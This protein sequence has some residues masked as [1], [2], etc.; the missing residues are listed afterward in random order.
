M[1]VW[2]TFCNVLHMAVCLIR[3]AA[4]SY[5]P[6][7]STRSTWTTRPQRACGC[8]IAR[9]TTRLR[10]GVMNRSYTEFVARTQFM[11]D[12]LELLKFEV[13]GGFET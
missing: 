5:L 4:G 1:F 3:V 6:S 7:S 8:G 10:L 11:D 9:G 2:Y 13:Y 12:L